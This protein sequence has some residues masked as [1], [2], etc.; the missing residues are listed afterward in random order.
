ME[1]IAICSKRKPTWGPRFDKYGKME[2]PFNQ[3]PSLLQDG[4]WTN[5]SPP[6][7]HLAWRCDCTNFG[8]PEQTAHSN[9]K[10]QAILKTGLHVNG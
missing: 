6:F 8:T 2:D 9:L 4:D 7:N 5:K 1:M 3:S 10:W